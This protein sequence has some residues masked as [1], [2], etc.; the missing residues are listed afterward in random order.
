MH[1]EFDAMS[2]HRLAVSVIC[3]GNRVEMNIMYSFCECFNRLFASA[4][5]VHHL[6][7]GAVDI[8]EEI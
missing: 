7:I 5:A 4:I 3:I 1:V 8:R 6:S 2:L